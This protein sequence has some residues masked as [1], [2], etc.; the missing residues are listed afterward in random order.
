MSLWLIA[1]AS[2]GSSRSVGMNIWDQCMA[3]YSSGTVRA[4]RCA[5]LAARDPKQVGRVQMR[6][7]FALACVLGLAAGRAEAQIEL[8]APLLTLE[9]VPLRVELFEA[10]VGSR[11]LYLIRTALPRSAA[12]QVLAAE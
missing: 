1:S 5:M 8:G 4:R 12:F 3:A 11:P 2:A 6:L 7:G 9:Q 10:R